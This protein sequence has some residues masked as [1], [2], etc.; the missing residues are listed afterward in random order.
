MRTLTN[1]Y[2]ISGLFNSEKN[3]TEIVLLWRVICYFLARQWTSWSL[4]WLAEIL[5]DVKSLP[6]CISG[7]T[8]GHEIAL[9]FS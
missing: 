7:F 9:S 3:K 4:C 5:A 2:F 6:G 1:S 8:A